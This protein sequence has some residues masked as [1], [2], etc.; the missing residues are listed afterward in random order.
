[1]LQVVFL[2]GGRVIRG[3]VAVSHGGKGPIMYTSAVKGSY[4]QN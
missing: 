3:V 2:G 1:M 4:Y